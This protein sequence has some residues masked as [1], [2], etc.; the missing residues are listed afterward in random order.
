[1][2]M[3]ETS[4]VLRLERS[5]WHGILSRTIKYYGVMFF[6]FALALLIGAVF[7]QT[8]GGG[9]DP[10][11]MI[12][13][14]AFAIAAVLMMFSDHTLGE[15]L[16][17]SRILYPILNDW[18]GVGDDE[19]VPEGG[20]PG[21]LFAAFLIGAAVG[22]V[23]HFVPPLYLVGGFC[24]VA[25]VR[26]IL[27]SPEAG[28]LLEFF[29]L[30]FMGYL[31]SPTILMA[32]LVI[33]VWVS[34]ILKYLLG[35]RTFSFGPLDGAVLIFAVMMLF[36]GLFSVAGS[37]SLRP[38]I[39]LTCFVAA[40]F[41]AANLL[42]SGEL[43]RRAVGVMVIAAVI[44]GAY[45]CFQYVGGTAADK[46]L[47]TEMFSDIAGRVTST[48]DNPN[49][50]AEYLVMT[51][52][53]AAAVMLSARTAGRRFVSLIGLGLMCAALVFTWS[54]GAWLGF[55]AA[56]ALFLLMLSRRTI[57]L[58]LCGAASI[59]FLPFILPQSIIQRFLSIGNLADSSTAY[60]V[61]I[62]EAAVK[63]IRDHFFSGIGVGEP[64]FR[65]VYT[66]YSLS[67]IESAPHSHSLFFQTV[68]E[69]G[70]FGL[71]ALAAVAL[72][73][74]IRCVTF[75]GRGGTL[76]KEDPR[77]RRRKTDTLLTAAGCCG[78]IAMLIQG[79]TDYVWYN[80][81][82]CLLFWL[83]IALTSAVIRTGKAEEPEILPDFER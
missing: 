82:V 40:Y 44:T 32:G 42:R 70:I 49:V 33:L 9:V 59:P 56:A 81:R 30:P 2:Q 25:A 11:I 41:P 83:V 64:A 10:K 24:A 5:F 13:G 16:R 63:M 7:D 75:L 3:A 34:Y 39:V 27:H 17:S 53:F 65:A 15:G 67:G 12:C 48:F 66:S 51:I 45:G 1:M 52:P 78:V 22:A 69:L 50:F 71:I 58:F 54:R 35:K 55:I 47:D 18:L 68:I 23:S 38:A 80:Y 8:S 76:S 79:L 36:G 46:W 4:R 73:F 19:L 74:L 31:P 43:I 60:R 20:K 62:W 6:A 14:I 61:H 57:I 26:F 21:R 72:L 28:V 37:A 77:A 29:L